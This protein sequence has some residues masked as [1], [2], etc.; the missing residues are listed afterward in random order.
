MIFLEYFTKMKKLKTIRTIA[1]QVRKAFEKIE[2]DENGY[3][4]NLGG[5]CFRASYQMYL[6]CKKEGINVDIIE[7]CGHYYNEFNGYIIDITATQFGKYPKIHI[8]RYKTNIPEFYN[9]VSVVTENDVEDP[10]Y[11]K[12]N[13]WD[14][15][16]ELE[17]DYHT[18]IDN[19]P[20][21]FRWSKG[22]SDVKVKYE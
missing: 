6:L 17:E 2:E 7:G 15:K 3:G 4:G 9:K 13:F 1:K 5:Y 21:K 12:Y 14:T 10:E 11:I 22:G 20:N 18:V 19:S 8:K 16:E